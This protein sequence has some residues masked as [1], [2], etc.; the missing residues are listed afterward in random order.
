VKIAR[1]MT[2]YLS[3]IEVYRTW[4]K[5]Q[6][7]AKSGYTTRNPDAIRHTFRGLTESP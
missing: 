4:C 6:L 7:I 3:Q 5:S 2:S 1:V